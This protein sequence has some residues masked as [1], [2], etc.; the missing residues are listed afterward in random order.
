MFTSGAGPGAGMTYHGG[1]H[2]GDGGGS[3]KD[4]DRRFFYGKNY[5]PGKNLVGGSTGKFVKTAFY[6]SF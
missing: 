6:F 2:G 1:G 5:L 4:S 3:W